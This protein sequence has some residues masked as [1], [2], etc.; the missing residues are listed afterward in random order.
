MNKEPKVF[1]KDVEILSKVIQEK[2][3][4]Q[5]EGSKGAGE[6][7]SSIRIQYLFFA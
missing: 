6:N 5:I 7:G 4:S 2:M 1:N 3:K